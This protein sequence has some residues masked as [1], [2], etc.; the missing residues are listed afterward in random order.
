MEDLILIG[1]GG[2]AK[3]CIDVIE[4]Q[5]AYRIRGLLD[6]PERVG[7]I[8]L[9]YPIVGTD[10][11][12][13]AHAALGHL[14][15]VTLGQILNPEPRA[16]LYGRIKAAGGRLASPVSPW[17]RV[18]PH[19]Q[20]GEGTIVMHHAMVGPGAQV[21]VN[22]ILNSGALVEHDV[23]VGDFCHLSTG[24]ILNGAAQVGEKSFV[25]SRS[26]YEQGIE[27]PAK[28]VI[29]MGSVVYVTQSGQLKVHPI[30]MRYGQ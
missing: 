1:A 19:A 28:A 12:I 29:P 9:G 8:F 27:T 21:G 20:V 2:H 17:A 6:R 26:V 13:E 14:F 24:A 10:Q 30:G 25:G 3:A 16:Q 5:G 4:A 11:E 18:S 22:C 15:L 7:K 23:V